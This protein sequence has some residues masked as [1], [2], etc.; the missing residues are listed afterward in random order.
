MATHKHVILR[1]RLHVD[2]P[3]VPLVHDGDAP[4][5]KAQG[6]AEGVAQ[7]D[8][9]VEQFAQD[10]PDVAAVV[11]RVITGEMIVAGRPEPLRLV[12]A[13]SRTMTLAPPSAAAMAAQPPMPPPTT[14]MSVS[15][16]LDA[17]S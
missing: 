10:G 5:K 8:K 3:L 2:A 12:L 11:L 6:K 9:A 17:E 4:L 7:P 16:V 15:S 1:E 13:F 14:A